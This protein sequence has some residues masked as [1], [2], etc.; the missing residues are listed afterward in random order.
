MRPAN[1]AKADGNQG[2][3]VVIE[4][5][6]HFDEI[7]QLPSSLKQMFQNP[8]LLD[9]FVQFQA[10]F[11][12]SCR[13]RYNNYHY[14]RVCKRRRTDEGTQQQSSGANLKTPYQH[15]DN[16]QPMCILCDES[17]SENLHHALTLGLDKKICDT[18]TLL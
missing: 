7:R 11:H 13:N 15:T 5:L 8:N 18:A 12:K 2:Y 14:S 17:E 3:C 9:D 4:N 1:V 10:M 16:F 6:K